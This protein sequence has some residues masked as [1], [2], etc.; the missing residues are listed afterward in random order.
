MSCTWPLIKFG[1]LSRTRMSELVNTFFSVIIWTAVQRIKVPS[2]FLPVRIP[3]CQTAES[4]LV[5]PERSDFEKHCFPSLFLSLNMTRELLRQTT[6]VFKSPPY[7][8]YNPSVQSHLS[9]RICKICS[10]YFAS[11]VM[12]NTTCASTKIKKIMHQFNSNTDKANSCCSAAPKRIN[13]NHR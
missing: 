13:G 9:E 3:L 8:L 1:F 6:R 12:L 5:T 11:R 10:L 4:G 7:D 2:R